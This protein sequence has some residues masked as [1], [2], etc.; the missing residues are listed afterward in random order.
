VALTRRQRNEVFQALEASG[1]APADC[2][3]NAEGM[4]VWDETDVSDATSLQHP[5]SGSTFLWARH[6]S[7]TSAVYKFE[8]FVTDGPIEEVEGVSWDELLTA[9]TKWADEVRYVAE[10][11]DL[12]ADL[13]SRP[14]MLAAAQAEG[15][16]NAPFTAEEQAEIAARIGAIKRQARERPELAAGQASGIEQK[17]DE[18]VQASGRVGRKDWITLLYG[19]AFGLIVNDAVPPHIVQGIIN[20]VIT[21]LGHIFGLGGVPPPLPQ[22]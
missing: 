18:L 5:L 17:L 9:I 3:L 7:M 19:A 14:M 20:S 10:T 8:S 6:A 2:K 12:W 1:M 13:N 16:S 4:A 22:V 15:A 11:P 21:G